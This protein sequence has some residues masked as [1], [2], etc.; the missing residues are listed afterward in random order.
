MAVRDKD[1]AATQDG[2]KWDFPGRMSVSTGVSVA[3]N[4][5]YT[6]WRVS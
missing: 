2:V 6:T 4:A 5:I 1:Y 3:P